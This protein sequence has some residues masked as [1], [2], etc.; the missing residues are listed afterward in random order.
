MIYISILN[1]RYFYGFATSYLISRS[2]NYKIILISILSI[3][4]NIIF[5]NL[6][7]FVC[8]CF[9][10]LINNIPIEVD[11]EIYIYMFFLEITISL[12]TNFY[13]YPKYRFF[14]LIILIL[15]PLFLM[16][17]KSNIYLLSVILITILFP[18]L[19]KIQD[20]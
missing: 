10:S 13:F 6:I 8:G 12:L 15:I 18:Y 16:T 7:L 11:N 14:L 19:L 4:L 9:V 2:T 3:I 20:L 1:V 17:I 5:I